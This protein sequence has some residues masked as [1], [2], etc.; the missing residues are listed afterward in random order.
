[1]TDKKIVGKYLIG[2]LIVI[3]FAIV[4]IIFFKSNSLFET[5]GGILIL[6]AG[7]TALI[8]SYNLENY[9]LLQNNKETITFTQHYKGMWIAIFNMD[10]QKPMVLYILIKPILKNGDFEN[11]RNKVNLL[12][13]ITYS[14]IIIGILIMN[15]NKN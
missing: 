5:F 14:L 10:I 9:F 15:M 7:I 13:Y 3:G 1:M 2:F 4:V 8:R 11:L 12:T 6:S